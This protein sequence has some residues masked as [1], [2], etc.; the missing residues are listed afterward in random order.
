MLFGSA[1]A[2]DVAATAR[3]ADRRKCLRILVVTSLLVAPFLYK[4]P[5]NSG[6]WYGESVGHYEGDTLVT[7]TVAPPS[8][9]SSRGQAPAARVWMPNHISSGRLSRIRWHRGLP[10]SLGAPK[11][12]QCGY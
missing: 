8:L 5:L 2:Y 9:L 1:E 3:V 6:S 12:D 10:Y 4:A 7:I 11:H